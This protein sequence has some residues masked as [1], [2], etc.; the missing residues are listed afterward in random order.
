[1]K[2]FIT[3]TTSGLGLS[4][5]KQIQVSS[6]ELVVLNRKKV[7]LENVSE[8]QISDL[9]NTNEIVSTLSNNL[10]T[11]G[12]VDVCILNAGTLGQIE[13]AVNIDSSDLLT[14]FQINCL[15]NKVIVD[16]LLK[17]SKCSRF[18]YISSGAAS[19]PYTG[20]LE[21]CSTKAFS[22]AMFRVY[23]KEM[24]DK[25]FVSIS[26]GAISTN[27]QSMIRSSSVEKYPDMKKFFDLYQ[28]NS[29]RDP[30]DAATKIIEKVKTLVPSDSGS[31]LKV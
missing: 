10:S 31:F 20:W 25:I 9:K 11:I 23:A 30:V 6:D 24:Q 4:L 29:L 22:D 15:S 3:G 12:D 18:V 19:S 14:T 13:E 8:I 2:F 1:M 16:F 26:P 21:Y 17:N 28:N 7:D 27:M 5:Q